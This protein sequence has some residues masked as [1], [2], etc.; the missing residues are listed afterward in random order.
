MEDA[1]TLMQLLLATAI[2]LGSLAAATSA[3]AYIACTGNVCWH[4]KERHEF[5]RDARVVIHEDTWKPRARARIE[6]R[7]HEGRGYWRGRDWREF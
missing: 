4:V 3:S 6:F 1:V 2:T 7:E 5:P